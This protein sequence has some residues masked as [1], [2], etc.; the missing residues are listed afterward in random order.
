MGRRAVEDAMHRPQESGPHLV[1][2]AHDD[3]GGWEVIVNKLLCTPGPEH[4]QSTKSM[5]RST[6]YKKK[7]RQKWSS[8]SL[9][10]RTQREVTVYKLRKEASQ[11]PNPLVPFQALEL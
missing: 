10:V 6:R 11:K 3:A 4:K 9:S 5:P 7:R 2:K 8:F 1:H